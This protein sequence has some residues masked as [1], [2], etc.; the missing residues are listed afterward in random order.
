VP[1]EKAY[2]APRLPLIAGGRQRLLTMAQRRLGAATNRQRH[3]SLSFEKAT[4]L[5]CGHTSEQGGRRCLSF[6]RSRMS[7]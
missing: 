5:A 3:T 6:L 7:L 2:E 4:Q 1:R